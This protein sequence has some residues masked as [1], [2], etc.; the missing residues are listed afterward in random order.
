MSLT[1]PSKKWMTKALGKDER[2]WIYLMILMILMMG[3]MTIGWVF[4]GKQ[5][6]PE[7]YTKYDNTDDLRDDFQAKNALAGLTATTITNG[8]GDT[9]QAYSVPAGGDVYMYAQRWQW[10]VDVNGDARSGLQFEAGERYRLHLG[11]IDVLH[12]FQLIG[13]DFIVSLQIVPAYDYVLDFTPDESGVFSII[14]NE[15]CGAGHQE[16][17]GFLEVTS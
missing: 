16:M 14:C 11:S 12:G 4:I 5:N 8:V 2:I 1:P 6:P 7:V 3:T 17:Y 15:F 10:L 9:I 13:G